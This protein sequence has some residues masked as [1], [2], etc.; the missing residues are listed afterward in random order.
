MPA[1]S[2]ANIGNLPLIV[3]S[4]SAA[5]AMAGDADLFVRRCDIVELRWDLI[6]AVGAKWRE[7]HAIWST[8]A[9]PLLMTAR[10]PSEGGQCDIPLAVLEQMAQMVRVGDLWDVE[11]ATWLGDRERRETLLRGWHGIPPRL[12]MSFHDFTATPE[13][14]DLRRLRD[15]ALVAGAHVFKV[16]AY[17]RS[18]GDMETLLALQQDHADIAV[19]TMGMGDLGAESRVRCALAGSV[20][21]Y[22]YL[23]AEPT[24]PGQWEAG[25]LRDVILEQMSPR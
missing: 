13:L 11:L 5:A 3:G 2:L 15:Q 17:L 10:V 9:K 4:L 7:V 14:D 23:G 16:A 21:N 22:G 19:A 8:A 20:L 24:A 6:F 18:A 1:N 12:V 25:K